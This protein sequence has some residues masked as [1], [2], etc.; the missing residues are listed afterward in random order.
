MWLSPKIC[1]CESKSIYSLFN[2]FFSMCKRWIELGVATEDI[3][4]K[5]QDRR[6]EEYITGRF[7]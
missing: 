4:L 3:F 7:G 6:T 1:H 5:P 2:I